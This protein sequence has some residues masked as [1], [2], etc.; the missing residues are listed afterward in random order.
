MSGADRVLAR[1]GGSGEAHPV[2]FTGTDT[3]QKRSVI[4]MSEM[5]MAT[6][7]VRMA[8]PP[9]ARRLRVHPTP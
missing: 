4:N 2:T 6:V 9:P 7:L 1:S 3:P 8:R 5:A